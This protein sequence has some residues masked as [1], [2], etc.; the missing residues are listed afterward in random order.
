[1]SY[2][3]GISPL[4]SIDIR[5]ASDWYSAKSRDLGLIFEKH[6]FNALEKLV[7]QPLISPTKYNKI[8]V[9]RIS[10]KFPFYLHYEVIEKDNLILVYAIFHGKQSPK[11]W[12]KRLNI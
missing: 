7:D 2:T 11:K 5:D 9:R 4:V 12:S 6:A 3:L 8:R 10:K 1:M